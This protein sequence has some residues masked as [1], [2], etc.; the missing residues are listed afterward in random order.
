MLK[1]DCLRRKI[2]DEGVSLTTL[3]V[4]PDH[5]IWMMT[6][7]QK[8]A[9]KVA[10]ILRPWLRFC[11]AEVQRARKRSFDKIIVFICTHKNY[12]NIT[13]FMH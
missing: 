3:A 2:V 11:F 10:D 6:S 1:I 8:I 13:I 5:V 9:V 7:L 12:T 4:T